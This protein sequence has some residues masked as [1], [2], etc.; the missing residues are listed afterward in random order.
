MTVALTDG[1]RGEMSSWNGTYVLSPK[2]DSDERNRF[3]VLDVTE[4][5]K[6]ALVG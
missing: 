3:R 5:W 1:D 4:A 6:A 2:L